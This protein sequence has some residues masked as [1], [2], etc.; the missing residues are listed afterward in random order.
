VHTAIESRRYRR[1]LREAQQK[2]DELGETDAP[3][4]VGGYRQLRNGLD[5]EFKRAVRYEHP[6]SCLLL[7]VDDFDQ[8]ATDSTPGQAGTIARTV[9]EVLQEHVR[10][11]D[12]V[13]QLHDDEFILLLPETPKSGA[14]VAYERI[15]QGLR[16]RAEARQPSITITA[17]LVTYPH[18][19]IKTSQDILL[20]VNQ[21]HRIA[22]EQGGNT[23]LALEE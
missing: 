4:G 21:L 20:S 9:L 10:V 11:V 23:M 1:L 6:L 19:S 14:K 17:A 16:V 13:Y 3:G 22:A 18:L 15:R 5:Y 8:L 7:T 2:L 12:R